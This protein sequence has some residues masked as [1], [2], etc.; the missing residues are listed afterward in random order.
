[1]SAEAALPQPVSDA[2]PAPAPGPAGIARLASSAARAWWESLE[3]LESAAQRHAAGIVLSGFERHSGMPL[4]AAYFGS[5]NHLAYV[6]ALLFRDSSVESEATRLPAWSAVRWLDRHGGGADIVVADLP[7]PWHL[8]ARGRGMIE[9]PAWINQRMCL[10]QRWQDVFPKLRRSARGEDM[11]NIRKNGLEYRLVRDEAAVRRFYED[12]YVPHLTRRFGDAAYIEPEWKIRYCVERG[13][14]MEIRRQ[15]EL[16]AAQV[17]W[18]NRGLLHFLWSGTTGADRGAET[19]GTFPALYYY[20]ILHA[21]E[22]GYDEVDYCGSRAVLTDGIFQLKRRWGASVYDGWSRDSLFLA[23]RHCAGANFEFLTRNPLI[24]RA[25]GGLVGKVFCGEAARA[26]DVERARQSYASDGVRE[27][28]LYSLA[29][30]LEDAVAAAR[31]SPGVEIVDLSGAQDPAA[32][33][34]R[35]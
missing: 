11:R 4:R 16:V 1:M 17:L 18:G 25:R 3:F 20:G 24:A 30:P 28:R 32:A 34:C 21:F 13:T 29:P 19:R 14:L 12:M 2:R 8:P 23:V 35:D 31:A 22:N 7:W 5:G 10:P 27:I 6:R 15:G 9:V 26:A 33:Y